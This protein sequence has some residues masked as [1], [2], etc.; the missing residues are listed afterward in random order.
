MEG[1][2]VI[3][4]TADGPSPQ[5]KRKL[6]H[7]ADGFGST[8]RA[9]GRSSGPA[10]KFTSAFD[11][12]R[13]SKL[14]S[15]HSPLRVPRPP[16]PLFSNPPSGSSKDTALRVLRPPPTPPAPP[17]APEAGPS[18][19][20][21]ARNTS[22]RPL[23]PPSFASPSGSGTKFTLKGAL[24]ASPRSSTKPVS[25][26]NIQ[27]FQP[28]LPVPPPAPDPVK[29]VRSINALQPP[30][31][32]LPR[33]GPPQLD[34][35]KLKTISTT[36]V[37]VAMDPRTESGTDELLALHIEQNASTY[38]PPLERE[39][40]RGLGQSPEK[41]SKKKGGKFVR[42]G[43]A[44]RAQHLFAKQ[45]TVQ[46]LWYKEMALQG[47]RPTTTRR[48]APDLSVRILAVS[49]TTSISSL[50]R[51]Q[52]IPRLCVVRCAKIIKGRATGELTVVLDFG[53]PGSLAEKA[54]T[55]EE[56]KEGKEV[57]VWRPWNSS[58]ADAE[59]MF[60]H[61]VPPRDGSTIFCTRF[62]LT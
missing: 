10:P 11:D 15:I 12:P 39:L 42:G 3:V 59:E 61:G 52:N 30:P 56:V 22:A 1:H 28:A 25:K 18:K 36:R 37:A 62:R 60:R 29:P 17:Q 14:T 6:M 32:P 19:P 21:P 16:P 31:P 20:Q 35:D 54:H 41:A 44:D 4:E 5:K 23:K 13:R 50:Q 49:H 58:Q 51:S 46:T 43:L 45:N 27:R 48:V 8:R 34:A 40:N 33:K 2:A 7:I 55:L 26:V 53:S 57:H 24:P 38:V 47:S 9:T